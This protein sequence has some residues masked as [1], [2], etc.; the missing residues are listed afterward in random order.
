M[1]LALL[2]VARSTI[3]EMAE[4]ETDSLE[5]WL[6]LALLYQKMR[7]VGGKLKSHWASETEEA[8]VGMLAKVGKAQALAA[9]GGR[10]FL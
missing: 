5:Q 1:P 3:P 4:M 2:A 7:A 8:T 10:E 9:L 6:K